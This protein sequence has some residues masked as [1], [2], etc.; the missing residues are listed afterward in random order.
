VWKKAVGLGR[1]SGIVEMDKQLLLK[2][3]PSLMESVTQDMKFPHSLMNFTQKY[4]VGRASRKYDKTRSYISFCL[5]R[6]N[7]T[8]ESLAC[9]SRKPHSHPNQHTEAELKQTKT[10]Q[11]DSNL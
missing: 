7:G 6:Y 10:H 2:G 11:Q 3:A 5:K 9:L 8:L 4:G 1:S